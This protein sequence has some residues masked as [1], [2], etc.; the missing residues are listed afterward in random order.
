MIPLQI[1]LK[2][3]LLLLKDRKSLATLLIT[4]LALTLILG[5]ALG[6]MWGAETPPSTVLYSNEDEGEWGAILFE[7]VFTVPELE[8]KFQLQ[9]ATDLEEAGKAVQRGE[10]T[11]LIHIPSEFS[12]EIAGGGETGVVLHGDPGSTIRVQII[13]AVVNR[14]A[15]EV[16]S[17]RVI[18]E[19]LGER[20]MMDPVTRERV[21]DVLAA[22]EVE[23]L[24]EDGS[25]RDTFDPVA[26]DYY[27]AGM[28]IM[29][30]LFT[31]T[32]GAQRFIEERRDK[33]LDRMLQMPVSLWQITLGK[34]TG[35]FLTGLFQ[36][37]VIIVA[38]TLLFGVYW[39]NP[40]GVAMLSAGAVCGATGIGLL[41]AS[42]ART[43]ETADSAGTFVVLAMSAIGGSMF[44]V[45]AMPPFMQ[46]LSNITLNHWA[47]EG[48]TK[49]M[50][51][52]GGP[53]A[54]LPYAG[55]LVAGGIVLSII[56][57]AR[58]AREVG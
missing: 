42:F 51:G 40:L 27:A 45:S 5:L 24:V 52:G 18:Y 12:S 2:D 30:L 19:A 17:R 33:T 48:F 7:E 38:S 54:V 35:I 3:L 57:G 53:E 32:T 49:L 26:I 16:S 36:I 15:A 44:P 4:P 20:G 34:F 1:A 6:S 39:G 22:M 46:Y 50:F 31:A 28:G 29:Y 11:A 13:E 55:I 9:Q 21:E 47:M 8:E 23:L 25:D 58:L 41:I 10:A 56:A 14:Y 37:S 43:P